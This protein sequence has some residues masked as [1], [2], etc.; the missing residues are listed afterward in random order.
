M[1]VPVEV[2]EELAEALVELV[3]A[4]DTSSILLDF[5]LISLK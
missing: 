3:E 1:L 2:V 4:L 5:C